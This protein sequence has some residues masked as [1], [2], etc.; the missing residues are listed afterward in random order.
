MIGE[1]A[2]EVITVQTMGVHYRWPIPECLTR[3]L[4]LATD[5]REDLVSLPLAY[6]HELQAIWSSY[7][8]VA[9]AEEA[10]SRA[11]AHL[12]TV[13]QRASAE[14]IRLRSK[15]NSVELSARLRDARAAVKSARQDRRDA[16]G[17]VKDE[18]SA[19]RA[20]RREQL[21]AD[22]RALYT[23]YCQQG[24]LFWATYNDVTE[25]HRRAVARITKARAGGRPGSLRHRRF[26]GTGTIAVQLQRRAGAPARTPAVLADPAGRYCNALHI[27]RPDPDQ[28]QRMS[29]AERRRAGRITVRMRC[30]ATDG[31]PDWID[32]PVQ[33]HRWLPEDAD[34]TGARLTV[35]RVGSHLSARLTVTARIDD[36]EPAA[37]AR[38]TV[39]VHLG[40][41]SVAEGTVVADWRADQ[42]LTIPAHLAGVITSDRD[43]MW[44]R[45]S[46]PGRSLSD[47]TGSPRPRPCAP[48]PTTRS[49]PSSST[50]SRSMDPSHTGTDSSARQTCG[51]GKHQ[52][53]SPRSPSPGVTLHPVTSP[54]PWTCGAADKSCGKAKHTAVGALRVTATTSTGRWPRRWHGSAAESLSMTPGSPR[55]PRGHASEASC[56]TTPRHASTAAAITPPPD[57]CARPSSPPLPAKASPSRWC[58]PPACRAPTPGAVTKTRPTTAT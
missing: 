5:L 32:I 49:T 51:G 22:Q 30:G 53:S 55:W 20:A 50:G 26:D 54:P 24:D 18:A 52:R 35:I 29:P 45:S 25:H 1:R 40:W 21:R 28:W 4:R 6:D 36:P 16:I 11:E 42:P 38:P 17:T 56:P 3:Q 9:A 44:A 47:S 2:Q 41:R 15:R 48:C 46:S 10:L 57:R 12:A 43:A 58:P 27:P 31:Q 14:R 7:P 39:V 37:S 8:G 13:T 23:R 34:I 33:A 19:G